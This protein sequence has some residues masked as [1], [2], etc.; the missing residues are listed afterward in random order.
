[1]VK[2]NRSSCFDHIHFAI[3]FGHLLEGHEALQIL[4]DRLPL[5]RDRKSPNLILSVSADGVLRD[6]TVSETSSFFQLM[7]RNF[8]EQMSA[9]LRHKIFVHYSYL[10]S[11][12]SLNGV[13]SEMNGI[14]ENEDQW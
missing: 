6:V 4:D 14:R 5:A 12:F 9:H 3:T 13:G 11:A 7:A 10:F 8:P 2:L 1:P